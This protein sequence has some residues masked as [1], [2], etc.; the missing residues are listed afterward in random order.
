MADAAPRPVF[1]EFRTRDLLGGSKWNRTWR[2]S[3]VAFVMLSLL[4]GLTGLQLHVQD[5]TDQAL[6]DRFDV[7]VESAA[8][9]IDEVVSREEL[10]AASVPTSVAGGPYLASLLPIQGTEAFIVDA[11]GAVLASSE[12]PPDNQLGA[13]HPSVARELTEQGSGIVSEDGAE[14]YFASASLTHRPWTLVLVAPS[15]RILEPLRH[16]WIAWLLMLAFAVVAGSTLT[17]LHRSSR[18][19]AD[20]DESVVE[21]TMQLEEAN[22]ELEA[23]AYS[24]SHDLRAPLRGIDGFSQVLADEL[25]GRLTPEAD[26]YLYRIRFNAQRMQELIDDLL[27]FSRLSRQELRHERIDPNRIVHDLRHLM[28]ADPKAVRC[29]WKVADLPACHGD[30]GLVRQVFSNLLDNARKYSAARE[31]PTIE[32]GASQTNADPNSITYYVRDNGVGFDMAYAD[33]L[34]GVFQRLHRAEEYEGTGVGLATVQRIVRRQGGQVWAES[35]P[36]SGATFYFTLE[37]G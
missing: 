17:L 29:Q 37:K 20:L 25:E 27:R 11:S 19:R 28:E 26:R 15:D 35:A 10:S 4:G 7:R 9:F 36:D 32:I 31:V 34:F 3:A 24:V 30:P 6:F 12:A 5:R 23:F 2:T 22:K 14:L 21:R 16:P 8:R 13:S 18:D 33:K 1:A